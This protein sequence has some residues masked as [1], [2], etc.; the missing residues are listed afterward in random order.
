M[1]CAGPGA[2]SRAGPRDG[3]G[4]ALLSWA[5]REPGRD[6]DR[7]GSRNGPIDGSGREPGRPGVGLGWSGLLPLNPALDSD[8]RG[9][10]RSTR[11]PSI[12]E[13]PPSLGVSECL[14]N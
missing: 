9:V 2:G 7:A 11:G 5:G 13:G 8:P 10:P 3:S 12:H 6:P 1:G 4:R 14:T